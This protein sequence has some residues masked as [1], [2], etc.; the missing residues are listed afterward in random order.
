M[1]ILCSLIFVTCLNCFIFI[2]VQC[3]AHEKILPES[4][5]PVPYNERPSSARVWEDEKKKQNEVG[6]FEENIF[7][8]FRNEVTK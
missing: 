1:I 2:F 3:I 5:N 8:D 6:K 4:P 7:T